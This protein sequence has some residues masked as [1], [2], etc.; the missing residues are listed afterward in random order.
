[1]Q[2]AHLWVDVNSYSSDDVDLFA[3]LD[4]FITVDKSNIQ[5]TI[6]GNKIVCKGNKIT[7]AL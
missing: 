5:D 1:M 7:L 6:V 3:S 2:A 4:Y